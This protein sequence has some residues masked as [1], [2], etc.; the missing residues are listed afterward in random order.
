[1]RKRG[2]SKH[3]VYTKP[4]RKAIQAVKDKVTAKTYRSTLHQEPAVL[5]QGISQALRGWAG[6][7]WIAHLPTTAASH[8]AQSAY[9]PDTT[10]S[11]TVEVYKPA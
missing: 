3:H 4:S 9:G 5:I 6:C 11:V 8:P 7:H 1:M 10:W 2:T